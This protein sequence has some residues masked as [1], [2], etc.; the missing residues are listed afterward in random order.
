M[1]NSQRYLLNLYLIKNVEN[2]VVFLGFTVKSGNSSLFSCSRNAQVTF[3]VKPQLKNNQLK[4]NK[5]R[6]LIHTWI[7]KAFK[8]SIE[9]QALIIHIFEWRVTCNNSDSPFS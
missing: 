6:Y 2:T 9:V 5:H 3:V 7:D 1:P 8:G 4:K